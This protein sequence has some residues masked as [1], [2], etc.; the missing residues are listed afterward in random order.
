MTIPFGNTTISSDDLYRHVIVFG[1]TGSGKTAYFLMPLL[2]SVLETGGSDP[3]D[4]P[5]AF[6]VDVKGDMARRCREILARVGREKDLLVV[7]R[8]GNAWVNPLRGLETDP[9]AVSERLLE[10]GSLLHSLHNDFYWTE[11]ARRLLFFAA[12]FAKVIGFGFVDSV[13]AV[14][15]ALGVLQRCIH[16]SLDDEAETPS[17]NDGILKALRGAKLGGYITR[18]EGRQLEAYLRDEVSL[19][20]RRTWAIILNY[21]RGFLANF[22]EGKLAALLV[23]HDGAEEFLPEHVI[24]HGRVVVLSL[25][26]SFYG[27]AARTL[28]TV[29]KTNFQRAV[30]QRAESRYFDG[31]VI[32]RINQQRPVYFLCDEFSESFTEGGQGIGDPFFLS[33]SREFRCSCLLATQGISALLAGAG[34]PAAVAHTLNNTA[35]KVFLSTNCATTTALLSPLL[36]GRAPSEPAPRF[37]LPGDRDQP[38]D[39]RSLDGSLNTLP[40]GVGIV[41]SPGLPPREV[42][43]EP[44][45]SP[46]FA[47]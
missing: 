14:E 17:I 47:S 45:F 7:G 39:L 31:S 12:V 38:G 33:E 26:G 15:K 36:N 35:T 41:V 43:F 28:R 23:P 22:L 32:R 16:S 13:C 37:H 30:L 21:A 3:E 20:P 44:I 27:P 46:R 24:D 29:L 42:R 18:E 19:L 40:V 11:N 1:S 25:S 9:R 34:S 10:T 6:L 8:H 4:K 2:Q 5:G